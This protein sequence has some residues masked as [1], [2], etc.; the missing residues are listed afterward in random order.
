MTYIPTE[1]LASEWMQQYLLTL[2]DPRTRG[3]ELEPF[4]GMVHGKTKCMFDGL[5][6]WADGGIGLRLHKYKG[7]QPYK[8]FNDVEKTQIEKKDFFDILFGSNKIVP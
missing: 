5:I 3:A 1:I 7:Q 4:H 8:G 2:I 6:S